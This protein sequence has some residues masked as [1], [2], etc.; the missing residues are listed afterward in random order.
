MIAVSNPLVQ[1]IREVMLSA[2]EFQ[3]VAGQ[4]PTLFGVITHFNNNT[5]KASIVYND[6]ITS[7]DVVKS[8]VSVGCLRG[9]HNRVNVG[10]I[11]VLAFPYGHS[12]MPIV[13]NIIP[14]D[15]DK[16][17]MPGYMSTSLSQGC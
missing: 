7:T 8:N 2:P 3:K 4:F 11:A 12:E 13:M 1:A 16:V 10:D 17:L 5:G 14:G 15:N 6:P 9:V